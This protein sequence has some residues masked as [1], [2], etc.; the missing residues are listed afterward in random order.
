M[1]E[2]FADAAP[3]WTAIVRT[4]EPISRDRRLADLAVKVGR[5]PGDF[6]PVPDP[7]GKAW[8]IVKTNPQCEMRAVESI[9][10]IGIH[11]YA[12]VYRKRLYDA[13]SKRPIHR[14]SP[15]IVGYVFVLLDAA[16]PDVGLI[17][18]CDGVAGVLP[19]GSDLQP[20]SIA[21]RAE[22][23]ARSTGGVTMPEMDI[24][25]IRELEASYWLEQD[26]AFRRR[27]KKWLKGRGYRLA[28]SD[29]VILMSGVFE[30]FVAAIAAMEGKSAARVVTQAFGQIEETV[31]PLDDL[32]RAA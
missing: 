18:D 22:P 21:N 20:V 4:R 14:V 32:L 16:R 10:R 17:R 27:R 28:T 8:F 7:A 9:L 30:G 5:K 12:P 15:F 11:A 24:E 3:R 1:P 25:A 19:M 29:P 23:R 31:L 2:L 6:I 26:L 13:R